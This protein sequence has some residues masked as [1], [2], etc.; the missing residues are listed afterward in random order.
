MSRSA[1]DRRSNFLVN[2]SLQRRMILISTVPMV[3]VLLIVLALQIFLNSRVQSELVEHGLEISTA[4]PQTVTALVF[5]AFTATFLVAMAL[6]LSHQVAGASYR[7][8]Q[9]L[10]A[11][12]E[13]DRDVRAHLR[14]G[15]LLTELADDLNDFLDW[16]DEKESARPRGGSSVA[17]VS[18]PGAPRSS[19]STHSHSSSLKQPA[20]VFAEHE[21]PATRRENDLSP[22]AVATPE[23]LC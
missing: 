1:S 5:F 13:G 11:Y 22:P 8:S 15:D 17:A 9:T 18:S 4:V 12:R 7:I 19:A 3:L 21:N 23:P 2:R 10:V 14:H 6:R 20:E 16:M